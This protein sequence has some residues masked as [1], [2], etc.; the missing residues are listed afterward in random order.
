MVGVWTP[1]DQV[2][3]VNRP[4]RDPLGRRSTPSSS[5]RSAAYR[6]RRRRR[7]NLRP[8]PSPSA[9]STNTH[10]APRAAVA[11]E[12][13][14]PPHVRR[15]SERGPFIH[16]NIPTT[17]PSGSRRRCVRA[18]RPLLVLRTRTRARAYTHTSAR[19]RARTRSRKHAY[20]CIRAHGRRFL[21]WGKRARQRRTDCNRESSATASFTHQLRSST[22]THASFVSRV[23]LAT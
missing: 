12:R 23:T 15:P 14:R 22:D 20:E 10:T 8:T 19:A 9:R 4:G 11:A 1:E 21:E 5:R 16:K 17:P 7:A 6:R 13:R 2:R 3:A 18:P